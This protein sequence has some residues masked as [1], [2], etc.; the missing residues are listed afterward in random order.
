M[1][2]KIT[3]IWSFITRH[4][5]IVTIASFV[6]WISFFDR[7]SLI[8][9][10]KVKSELEILKAEQKYYQYKIKKNKER[11]SGLNNKKILEK[12]AREEYYMKKDN[13]DI[14]VIIEK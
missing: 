4:K 14:Y 11:L 10:S 5:Y 2:E 1:K 3:K 8:F 6:I 7:T 13:E 9:K 12:F